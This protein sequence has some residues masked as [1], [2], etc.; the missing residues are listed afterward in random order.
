MLAAEKLLPT[1]VELVIAD[2]SQIPLY[3]QDLELE[4]L[5]ESVVKLKDQI[6]NSDCILFATPEYNY[7]VPGV[8]KNAIDWASRPPM[9]SPLNGKAAAIMSASGGML[10]GSRAQY[11]LRQIFVFLNIVT[12]NKPEVF[13]PFAKDKFNEQGELIDDHTKEK[14]QELLVAL[15][16]LVL[17]LKK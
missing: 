4:S 16:Q 1:G 17:Q 13:V 6:L 8:L 10:G 3:N 9:Q 15:E 2:I 14:I 11:H 7:S 12:L 5:P